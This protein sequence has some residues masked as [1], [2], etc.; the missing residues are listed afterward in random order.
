[1]PE[2]PELGKQ[3]QEDK[4]FDSIASSGTPGPQETF[5][6]ILP[7]SFLD[8]FFL[9]HSGYIKQAVYRQ[10]GLLSMRSLLICFIFNLI[11]SII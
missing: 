1:M 9:I 7:S 8:L 2:I 5:F 11:V 6:Q 10:Q 4:M 3:R